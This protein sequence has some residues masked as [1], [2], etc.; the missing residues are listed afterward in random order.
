MGIVFQRLI[1]DRKFLATYYT[2]PEA[3]AL[4]SALAL[5]ADRPPGGSDWGD[6]ETLAGVQVGDFACGTGTLLSTAYQ[7]M[8]LLHELHGGD[9][10]ALHRPM[11]KHGLVGLDVLPIAV[12]LTAAMLAGSHPDTPFDGECL[13]TMPYG[14]AVP[15]PEWQR[16]CQAQVGYSDRLVGPARAAGASRRS[17]IRR[18]R[19]RPVAAR[20]KRCE[21]WSR[22]VGHGRFDLVIMNP[23]FTRPTNHEGG[24][25]GR[26]G[27][28]RIR[29]VRYTTPADTEEDA[30]LAGG[31]A[32]D[33]PDCERQCGPCCRL[34][35]SRDS[36]S[37]LRR[38]DCLG[39]SVECCERRG[40]GA[41]PAVARGTL[42][43]HHGR[44]DCGRGL[45]RRSLFC[46]YGN[47]GMSHHSAPRRWRVRATWDIRGVA[48][49][50]AVGCRRG[51][52]SC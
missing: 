26:S 52:A 29:C 27:N 2:R 25:A 18:L 48:P 3:A 12:H 42:W 15:K 31:A 23:P 28:P 22:R 47:G 35:R 5:P 16:Q 10:E 38:H 9:S 51:V 21:T 41:R 17:L 4:L 43:R 37:P 40:V 32:R 7:R 46:G 19:C 20:R 13:L 24:H 11:M 44:N 45:I 33:G 50:S 6:A 1:A 49:E 36:E 8:S 14:K 34:P 30:G 39:A